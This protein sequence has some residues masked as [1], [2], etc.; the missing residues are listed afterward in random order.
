MRSSLVAVILIRA[1]GCTVGD[2]RGFAHL[3]V[4]L[5]SYDSRRLSR[6]TSAA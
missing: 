3:S 1:G 5:T 6:L 4:K 2:G